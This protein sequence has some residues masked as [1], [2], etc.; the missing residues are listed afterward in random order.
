MKKVK[1][2]PKESCSLCDK[3][4]GFVVIKKDDRWVAVKCK[5][6]M[7]AEEHLDSNSNPQEEMD[8]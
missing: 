2:E 4:S 5:C 7:T 1:I 3:N 6:M 8:W